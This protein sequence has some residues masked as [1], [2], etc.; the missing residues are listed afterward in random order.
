MRP[1]RQ[2]FFLQLTFRPRLLHKMAPARRIGQ[3]GSPASKEEIEPPA[4]KT[5]EDVEA[6]KSNLRAF[7]S[8][9][10][11]SNDPQTKETAIQ[12]E[13]QFKSLK[14]DDDMSAKFAMRF[15]ETK[16]TKDFSWVKNFKESYNSTK[17]E[18]TK[19]NESYL[20]RTCLF[21]ANHGCLNI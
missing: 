12:M 6:A 5:K 3:K 8:Y 17:D 18:E 4:K 13:Q 14:N 11:K 7:V 21:W 1:T 20:T 15:M 9:A 10:K 19:M 2:F 16:K